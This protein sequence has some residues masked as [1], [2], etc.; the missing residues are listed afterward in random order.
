MERVGIRELRNQVSAVIRRARAGER[1]VITSN[2]IPVAE[3]GLVGGGDVATIE[4]LAE[5]GLIRLPRMMG[6]LPAPRPVPT[7][8]GVTSAQVLDELRSR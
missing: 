8:P 1:I 5:A 7:K 3:I 2:G 4:Q 6:Y